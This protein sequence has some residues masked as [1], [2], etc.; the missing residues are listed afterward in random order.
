MI[1]YEVG[2]VRM[3]EGVELLYQTSSKNKNVGLV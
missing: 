1:A 3:L 2:G